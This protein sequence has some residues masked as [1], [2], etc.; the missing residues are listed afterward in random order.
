MKKTLV[1]AILLFISIIGVSAQGSS[2]KDE[3]KIQ[4]IEQFEGSEAVH[5]QYSFK[6][7]PSKIYILWRSSDTV[8]WTRLHPGNTDCMFN[9]NGTDDYYHMIVKKREKDFFRVGPIITE[10]YIFTKNLQIGEAN[11]DVICLQAFL[12]ERGYIH[13][14][15][16]EVRGF[17]DT[18]TAEALR[19][20]QV[21]VGI[22]SGFGYFGPLSRVWFNMQLQNPDDI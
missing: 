11:D 17:F 16:N 7:R 9:Y 20:Y 12:E 3:V 8:N 6:P 10:G 21:S 2:T 13:F 22:V 4:G 5:V 1:V 18:L 15:P 14:P 19:D